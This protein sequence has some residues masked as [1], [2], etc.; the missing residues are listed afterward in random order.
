MLPPRRNLPSRVARR[1]APRGVALGATLLVAAAACRRGGATTA[2]AADA[3]PATV[4]G[5]EDMAVVRAGRLETGPMLSGTLGAANTATITALLAGPVLATHVDVGVRVARGQL[6]AQLDDRTLQDAMRSA[7]SAARAAEAAAEN[8]RR[9]LSRQQ[10]LLAIEAVAPRDVERA[11]STAASA[12]ADVAD[13]RARVATSAQQLRYGRVT[14]PIDGVVS[15]R[16]ASTGDV[17]AAGA[18]LFTIIDPSA[19]RLVA[20]VPADGLADVRVGQP[21]A[22]T[23][24]GYGGRAFAGRITQVSPAVDP[25]TRQVDVYATIPNAGRLVSG[26]FASGRVTTRATDGL[27]APAGVLDTREVTPTVVRLRAGRVERVR[28]Q[29]GARDDG[30]KQVLLTGG[31]VAGDTLLT[32]AAQQLPAAARVVVAGSDVPSPAAPHTAPPR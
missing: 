23:V 30:T 18:P 5:P 31:V 2:D 4:V 10:Q 3:P 28:V 16:S 1:A 9:E 27:V 6:L 7:R 12:A 29:V 32:R 8:A 24:R 15:V 21:V 17:V 22:F 14:S 13:A 19:M 20:S 25:A 11:R 26:L